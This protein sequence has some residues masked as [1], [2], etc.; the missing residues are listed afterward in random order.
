MDCFLKVF[1]YYFGIWLVYM[2]YSVKPRFVYWPFSSSFTFV[3]CLSA[4][5]RIF[6]KRSASRFRNRHAGFVKFV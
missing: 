1:V 5:R 4:Y 3:Y 2:F 6:C